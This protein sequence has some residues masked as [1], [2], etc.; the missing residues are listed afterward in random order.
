MQDASKNLKRGKKKFF[1]L[2]VLNDKESICKLGTK[3][4]EVYSKPFLD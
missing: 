4:F 2:A 1:F 3:S